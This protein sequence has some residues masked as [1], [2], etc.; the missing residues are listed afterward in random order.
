MEKHRRIILGELE[1]IIEFNEVEGRIIK[2]YTISHKYVFLRTHANL[3]FLIDVESQVKKILA[4]IEV[5]NLS[6]IEIFNLNNKICIVTE[7]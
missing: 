1:R 4:K 3:L 6:I 2:I 5:S 7:N